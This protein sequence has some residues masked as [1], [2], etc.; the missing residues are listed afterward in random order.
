MVGGVF[1]GLEKRIIVTSS[2][3]PQK[4]GRYRVVKE[5]GR[6]G[7]GV[8]YLARDP[9]IDRQVAIKTSLT[10]PPT[11][12]LEFDEYQHAFFNEA[13]AAGK[14][15]HRNIVAVYDAFVDTL[16][17]YLVME[18]VEGSTLADF[19]RQDNLLPVNKVVNIV[20]LCAKALNFAH[21][22]GVVHRDVKP[23]NILMTPN[24]QPKISDFGIAAIQ[25]AKGLDYETP[26]TGSICYSSPEQLRKDT[27]TQQ[28]DI[29]SLGVVMYELLTGVRPF[30]ADTGVATF[31]KITHEDPLPVRTHRQE[32]P[33]S[34]ERILACCLS[35]DLDN[36]YR[37]GLQLAQAL[38]A[39]FDHLKNLKDEINQEEKL[40]VLKKIEFFKSFTTSEL[41]E[42]IKTT[43]WVRHESATTIISE[44]EIEDYFY[45]LVSG[46]VIVRK[47][48]Q[49]LAKIQAGEC[50]GEMAYLGRTKRTATILAASNSILMKISATE[51]DQMSIST[52]LRFFKIFSTTLI[53]RLARTSDLLSKAV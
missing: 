24:G 40:Q 3:I 44:G 2:K 6:G 15:T 50:F 34:L 19:C 31:Y 42:V 22:S 26:L 13:R 5:I 36:R 53:K 28:S 33:E 8:V 47:R 7:M 27:L 18:Y 21:E 14:L 49:L 46:E 4:I 11:D 1:N 16:H 45:I 38:I 32:L 29:F 10:A 52:Q 30:E 37:N 9:F 39:S 48:G 12:P 23:K 17:S 20:F 51:L 25:G 43:Q 41:N 35:R